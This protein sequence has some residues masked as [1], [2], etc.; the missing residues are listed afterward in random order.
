MSGFLIKK[1]K[2]VYTRGYFYIPDWPFRG[3][4]K[5]YR[6]FRLWERFSDLTQF[7]FNCWRFR[8]E[9]T[10]WNPT[11]G[12]N[13]LIFARRIVLSYNMTLDPS[14][15]RS[16]VLEAISAI[17]ALESEPYSL[18]FKEKAEKVKI[19]Q[20]FMMH[21]IVYPQFYHREMYPDLNQ[22]IIK[23]LLNVHTDKS[24]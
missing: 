6:L 11:L 23:D 1:F 13:W 19:I 15:K 12:H 21:P 18:T 5:P 9:L 10:Q 24:S 16:S 7:L 4:Y 22:K 17:E 2:T 14:Q 8:K 20:D 3:G